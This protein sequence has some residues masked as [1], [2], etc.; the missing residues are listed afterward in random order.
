[1]NQLFIGEEVV[2]VG[3]YPIGSQNSKFMDTIADNLQQD[4]GSNYNII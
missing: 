2:V 1:M 4:L 3:L